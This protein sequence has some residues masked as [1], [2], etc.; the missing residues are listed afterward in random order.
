VLLESPG[1]GG[2]FLS[3]VSCWADTQL[4]TQALLSAAR[5]APALALDVAPDEGVQA[6]EQNAQSAIEIQQFPVT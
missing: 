4:P 1:A 5:S 2:R 3:S 6:T